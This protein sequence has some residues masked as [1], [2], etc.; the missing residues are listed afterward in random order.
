MKSL[1]LGNEDF[2]DMSDFTSSSEERRRAFQH[3]EE[4]LTGPLGILNWCFH[5]WQHQFKIFVFLIYWNLF[6]K[7][8]SVK[9]NDKWSQ[10]SFLARSALP[11]LSYL[12][13]RN[14]G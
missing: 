8:D 12:R 13:A 2:L 10:P 7:I 14:G 5:D 11:L 1:C 3:V 9:N 6:Q 4:P